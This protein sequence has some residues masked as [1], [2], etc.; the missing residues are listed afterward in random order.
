MTS[1]VVD[2]L[3]RISRYNLS[4]SPLLPK[5]PP[6]SPLSLLPSSPLYVCVC[7]SLALSELK[8]HTLILG[9]V[10]WLVCLYKTTPPN[11]S[12]ASLEIA[13]WLML[14]LNLLCGPDNPPASVSQLLGL[15]VYVNMFNFLTGVK[16]K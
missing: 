7:F 16:K 6:L 3:F 8:L 5:P 14:A 13:M 12:S 11:G 9:C 1:E 4:L 10:F 15:Q 2:R